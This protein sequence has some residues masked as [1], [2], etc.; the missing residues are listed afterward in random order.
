MTQPQDTLTTLID[1]LESDLKQA[2][3]AQNIDS[4]LTL[5][6]SAMDQLEQAAS[7]PELPHADRQRAQNTAK[8]CGYNAAA[9][10]WP[11]WDSPPPTRTPESLL[12]ARAIAVRV[13]A[14][15]A[16]LPPSPQQLGNAAWL[17]G[18]FNLALGDLPSAQHHF[19]SART[20]FEPA[21]EMKLMAEGYLALAG[22]PTVPALETTIQT[23][24]TSAL[25]N[26]KDLAEQI[27]TAA[28]SWRAQRS[29][30]SPQSP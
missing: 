6:A 28:T 27:K 12:A 23:L 22:D 20:H 9:D 1:R 25:P 18:A 4:L 17:I 13:A 29:H 7:H 11:F 14:L 15:T 16:A 19:Q 5:T 24:T 30:P 2:R 8:K 21:P 10:A 26:A 3:K